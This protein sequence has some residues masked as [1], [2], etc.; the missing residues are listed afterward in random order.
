MA[1]TSPAM[2]KLRDRAAPASLVL[3]TPYPRPLVRVV[4]GA[5]L[6]FARHLLD[7]A[8]HLLLP[9][10]RRCGADDRSRLQPP[11]DVVELFEIAIA[12]R[13][14]A[15]AV[16][17]MNDA[18]REPER[19]GEALLERR[20]IR[21]G[22][23]AAGAAHFARLLAAVAARHLFDLPHIQ[24]ALDDQL[25]EFLG[26][27]LPDQQARVPG[28]QLTR[29]DVGLHGVGQLQQPDRVADMRPALA[30]DLRDLVLAVLEFVGERLIALR[31]FERVEVGA[32]HVL[33]DGDFERLAIADLDE[34]HRHVVQ[35]R[36]LRRAPAPFAGDDLVLID[37]AA[38]RAHQD[39]LNDAALADRRHK[40]LE[41]GFREGA[42][43]VAR[44]RFDE[45]D[46][47]GALTARSLEH[48]G[49]VADIADQC[50]QSAAE[51]RPLVVCHAHVLVPSLAL[52][53][54]GLSRPS[55]LGGHCASL[56]GIAGTSPA[57]TRKLV[58]PRAMS[59]R[60]G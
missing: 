45:F 19:I 40:L 24:S 29:I 53:W 4:A 60:A 22:T 33:D 56:S 38:H 8:A 39:R 14:D 37:R 49:F 48:R 52:S 43:R 11:R 31:L 47:P 13:Q 16:G 59:A 30:D 6:Q 51:A 18:H 17:A 57:M 2:T 41:L 23:D 46:R 50:G 10:T 5:L 1:G 32:L 21:I 44:I 42:A 20:G 54:P 55:R 28:R 58:T 25:G 34:E 36:A 27:R 7:L 26:I 9:R 12:D 15:L 3:Q 35:A